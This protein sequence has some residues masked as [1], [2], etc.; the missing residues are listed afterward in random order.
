[1]QFVCLKTVVLKRPSRCF[2]H[3]LPPSSP[4]SFHLRKQGH[5]PLPR[6][7]SV[8]KLHPCFSPCQSSLKHLCI[9]NREPHF[10]LHTHPLPV[11]YT[12]FP[13]MC[14]SAP[15]C[16]IGCEVCRRWDGTRGHN[17][18]T[19]TVELEFDI[20]SSVICTVVRVLSLGVMPWD[21]CA[22]IC[23][24]QTDSTLVLSVNFT[25]SQ[26]TSPIFTHDS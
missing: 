1:M 16:D 18:N 22:W 19:G 4:T 2:L 14:L 12:L 13:G 24:I 21:G 20:R 17:D 8:S 23:F 11:W 25:D 5:S 15:V 6:L 10:Q 26:G 3:F 9:A 7:P